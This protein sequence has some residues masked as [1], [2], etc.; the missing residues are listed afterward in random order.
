MFAFCCK[1][2]CLYNFE[3]NQLQ[4]DEI[5]NRLENSD[6]FTITTLVKQNRMND[7]LNFLI[8]LAD[9]HY[10][11]THFWRK[12][13][14]Y[15]ELSEQDFPGIINIVNQSELKLS[16]KYIIKDAVSLKKLYIKLPKEN[17]YVDSLKFEENLLNSITNEFLRVISTLKPM[18]IKI[19]IFNQNKNEI[20]FDVNTMIL[21]QGSDLGFGMKNQQTNNSNNK[22]E[23]LLT[24]RKDKSK[25]DLSC[26]LDK[27]KFY[28]LP[29]Y[30]EWMDLIHNRVN[31]NVNTAKYVYEH[32][33]DNNINIEFLEKM[34]LLS[35][36]C[37][38]KKSKY[39]NIRFEYEIDYYPL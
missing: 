17:L 20:E 37:K 8:V 12:K 28:Y 18:S 23:W 30:T 24:F 34:K 13:S 2:H 5:M 4:Y 35:I 29:K 7:F 14:L 25:M 32:T 26:F 3:I 22:K 19:Q 1:D 36:D 10:T 9:K 11:K 21:F 39:E 27:S 31:Y 15:D 6:T 33:T 38:Y 16:S